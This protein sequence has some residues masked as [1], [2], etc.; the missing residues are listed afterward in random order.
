MIVRNISGTADYACSCGSWLKHWE[1]YSGQNLPTYCPEKNCLNKVL[2][3]AHVQKDSILD[4]SWY[5]IPLCQEHNKSAKS[6][7][8]ANYIKLVSANRSGTCGY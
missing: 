1:K 2:V 4:N 6:L 7:E 8:V 5:I 3:G